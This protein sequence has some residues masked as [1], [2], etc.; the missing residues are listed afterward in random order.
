MHSAQLIFVNLILEFIF[1]IILLCCS[2]S[3]W[4]RETWSY[5]K[6]LIWA[7]LQVFIIIKTCFW[8]RFNIPSVKP[9]LIY[10]TQSFYLSSF[11]LWIY[12]VDS[13]G[14]HSVIPIERCFISQ[15]WT[16]TFVRLC[17]ERKPILSWVGCEE[18]IQGQKIF[19]K[20]DVTWGPFRLI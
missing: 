12:L 9:F 3:K 6:W 8:K 10:V 2:W 16:F 17:S 11:R 19:L 1:L 5:Y 14:A 20:N 13:G 4:Q 18:F 7:L 15:P